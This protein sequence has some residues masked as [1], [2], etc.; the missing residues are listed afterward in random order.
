MCEECVRVYV[1]EEFM[2]LCV[3]GCEE[4]VCVCVE[5]VRSV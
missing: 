2:Y 5:Y 4:C 1:C 3:S